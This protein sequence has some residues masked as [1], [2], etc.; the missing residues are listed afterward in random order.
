TGHVEPD[1]ERA[2]FG[3]NGEA[4]EIPLLPGHLKD[5]PG[6]LQFPE[7]KRAVATQPGQEFPF[8]SERRRDSVRNRGLEAVQL[9]AGRR[10]PQADRAVV[11]GRR[12]RLAVGRERD[13]D[14]G[15]A[16]AKADCPPAGQRL[17]PERLAVT[18][19]L[20]AGAPLRVAL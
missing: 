6:G 3:G 13:R 18:V 11:T 4:L 14:D 12:Q 2:P 15:P 5:L 10:L 17:Q 20:R 19:C 1:G 16:G 9:L 8:L 7:V